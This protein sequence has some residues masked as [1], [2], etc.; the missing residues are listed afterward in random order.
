MADTIISTVIEIGSR[1]CVGP[2][3]GSSLLPNHNIEYSRIHF[4]KNVLPAKD[5][6][7]LDSAGL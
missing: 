6:D 5:R 4:H 3:S 2:G 1:V 7:K